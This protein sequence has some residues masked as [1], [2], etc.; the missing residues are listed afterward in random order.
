M[1]EDKLCY[2]YAKA[3]FEDAREKGLL[4]SVQQ[5]MLFLY[6]TISDNRD[7]KLFLKS[8]IISK[9]KKRDIITSIFG[10]KVSA[11]T[12]KAIFFLIDK[13]REGFLS[14]IATA[15]VKRYNQYKNIT[16]VKVTT[17]VPMDEATEAAVRKA[18]INKIGNTELII[19]PQV[20]PYLLGGFVIDFGDKVFDASVRHRLSAISNELI[21]H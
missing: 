9:E 14:D 19:K 20:D 15:F 10:D 6:K 12:I 1:A 21:H 17:A 4:E 16:Y 5:D 13:G 3:F 8:P 7:L 2:R 18:I 11:Y